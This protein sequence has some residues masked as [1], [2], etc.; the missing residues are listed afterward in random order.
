MA[1]FPFNPTKNPNWLEKLSISSRIQKLF[2]IKQQCLSLSQVQVN[3][4]GN[5]FPFMRDVSFVF[6]FCAVLL[7][8]KHAKSTQYV[9]TNHQ[10][11]KT[12]KQK[13]PATSTKN[14]STVSS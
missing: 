11:K 14:K 4:R 13:K 7:T 1:V 5:Q 3:C 6:I 9:R 8:F 2:H 10:K 12:I